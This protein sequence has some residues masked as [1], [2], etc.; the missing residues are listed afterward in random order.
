MR[1]P[2][3]RC[4]P[5][6][7]SL[8]PFRTGKQESLE[9]LTADLQQKVILFLRFHAFRKRFHAQALCHVDHRGQDCA[10]ARILRQILQK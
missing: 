7:L 6:G 9:F 10:C 4:L 2:V 3:V 5:F 1:F 8:Q